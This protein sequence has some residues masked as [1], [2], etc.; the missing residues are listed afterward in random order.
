MPSLSVWLDALD[1]MPQLKTLALYWASPTAP[2]GASLTFDVE[3]TVTLPSLTHID[4]SASPG[5]CAL[6]L[7]HLV[8]PVLTSLCLT[9]WSGLMDGGDVQQLLPYVA[10]HAHGPQ[11]TRPLQSVLTRGDEAY[12]N[13]LAWP[14]P[15]IDVEAHDPLT[16]LAAMLS[17]RVALSVTSKVWHS[18]M[19]VVVLNA[20][21]AALPLDALDSLVTLTAQHHAQQIMRPIYVVYWLRCAPKWLL[22]RRVRLVHH[23]ERGFI[24]MLLEDNGGRESPLLPSLTELIMVSAPLD[25]PWT[26]RLCDALMKRVEQGVPL[27]MLDLRACLP[28]NPTVVR[29]LSEIVVDVLSPEKTLEEREAINDMWDSVAR[30]LFVEGDNSGAEDYSDTRRLRLGLRHRW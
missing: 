17:P 27:Q 7:A 12:A 9:A 4:I 8:L 5:D 25:E 10:Q 14:V 22:L 3:R 11:D 23:V 1:K 26:L 13:I 6:A 30:G 29:L 20:A 19:H 24:T 21:M 15:D 2:P 16:L 18:Q 28:S